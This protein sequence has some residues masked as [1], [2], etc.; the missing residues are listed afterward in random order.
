MGRISCCEVHSAERVVSAQQKQLRITLG[1]PEIYVGYLRSYIHISS[2]SVNT[3]CSCNFTP[4]E[5]MNTL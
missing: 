4:P 5:L 1:E 3:D 2:P